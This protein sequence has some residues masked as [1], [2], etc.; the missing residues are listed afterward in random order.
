MIDHPVLAAI[1]D[2]VLKNFPEYAIFVTALSIA[3]VCTWPEF[4]PRSAQ[5]WWTWFRNAFQTA[6]PAA[7][8]RV[9]AHSTTTTATPTTSMKQE[10][11]ASTAVD[12]TQPKA[13]A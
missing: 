1:Q 5:D 11:T 12:P 9:E 10:A 4:I 13:G 7:R 6:V 2:H 3:F 8:A